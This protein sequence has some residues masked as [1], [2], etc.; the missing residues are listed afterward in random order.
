MVI[1]RIKM[2]KFLKCVFWVT[3]VLAFILCFGG[4]IGLVSIAV[5]PLF[6]FMVP[7][8]FVAWVLYLLM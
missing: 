5:M 2:S 6:I 1:R 4:I 7:V 3:M 8:L